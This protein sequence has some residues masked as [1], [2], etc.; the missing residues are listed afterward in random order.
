M[1]RS[2]FAAVLFFP[3]LVHAA[4]D[5]AAEWAVLNEMF[6]RRGP[7]T[8]EVAPDFQLER[9]RGGTVHAAALWAEKPLLV[10][11]GSYSCPQFRAVTPERQDLVR[12]FSAQINSVILYSVEAHPSGSRSPYFGNDFFPEENR[13]EGI[14]LPQPTAYRERL[15]LARS[16]RADFKLLSTVAVDRM[17]NAVWKA[18]GAAPNC[19]YLID[20]RGRVVFRQGFLEVAPLRAA[21]KKLLGA[22]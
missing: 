22:K 5:E 10:T 14:L 17:D 7:K 12:E 18:Y 21:I 3:P 9:A 15:S 11:T 2:L 16:C 6:L 13:R 19:A 1:L 20:T 8:G 4:D